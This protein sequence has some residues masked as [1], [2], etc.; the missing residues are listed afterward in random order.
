MKV[1]STQMMV[2]SKQ[3]LNDMKVT[4]GKRHFQ[5]FRLEELGGVRTEPCQDTHS[6]L[7]MLTR[8]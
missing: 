2:T 4:C 8:R 5:Y 6:L 1:T 3:S 7:V